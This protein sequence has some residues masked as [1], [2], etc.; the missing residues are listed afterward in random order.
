LN[1][2]RQFTSVTTSVPVCADH[3]DGDALGPVAFA[4]NLQPGDVIP[5]GPGRHQRVLN[6]IPADSE[7][8]YPF[9]YTEV[10]GS[11]AGT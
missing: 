8:E 11:R 4:E 6:V 5:V 10:L 2:R 3:T 1:L 9:L 7:D